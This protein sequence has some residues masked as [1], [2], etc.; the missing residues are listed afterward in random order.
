VTT[1]D[2]VQLTENNV[3]LTTGK[4]L[5]AILDTM[6]VEK[7][8]ERI[9]VFHLAQKCYAG[10]TVDITPG[11]RDML[12]KAV[13]ASMIQSNVVVGQLRTLLD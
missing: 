6:K 11:E 1:L 4:V 2:G 7:G 12:R 9:A 10:G 5:A 8:I 3:K 13:D